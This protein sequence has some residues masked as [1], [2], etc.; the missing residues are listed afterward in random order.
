MGTSQKVIVKYP[1]HMG[2]SAQPPKSLG[3]YKL[4][5]TSSVTTFPPQCLKLEMTS[6][7]KRWGGLGKVRILLR[8]W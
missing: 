1:A 4:E 8:W 3:K 7:T 5:T 6:G 2:K